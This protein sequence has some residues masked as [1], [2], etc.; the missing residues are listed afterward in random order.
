MLGRLDATSL[1]RDI[2]VAATRF[3]AHAGAREGPGVLGDVLE[4]ALAPAFVDGCPARGPFGAQ[5]RQSR[6]GKD[7]W[8]LFTALDDAFERVAAGRQERLERSRALG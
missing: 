6:A 1:R 3:S 5:W 4:E 2:E 7:Q 8:D